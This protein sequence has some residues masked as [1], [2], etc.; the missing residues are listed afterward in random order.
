MSEIIESQREVYLENFLTN[1]DS[2]DGTFNSNRE[3]QNCRFERL[4]ANLGLRSRRYRLHDVGCGVCDLYQYLR[5]QNIDVD[6]TGT[7]I[8]QQMKLAAHQK[9]PDVEVSIRDFTL[10]SASD[11]RH[12]FVTLAGAFNMPGK[13]DRAEWA[14]FT[15]Q[16]ILSMYR[17]ATCGISFNFLTTDADFYHDDLYYRDP[18]EVRRF[19]ASKLSRHTIVDQAYPLFE[20]TVTVLKP[21][22]VKERY[23]SSSF[24]RYFEKAQSE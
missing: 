20:Y 18:S 3:L 8:L 23:A 14:E 24:A 1:G 12:D 11:E 4:I 2:P 6:Y 13:T 9:F 16:M 7:E 19:C 15:N 22:Y 17:V 5:Q 21:N 10:L